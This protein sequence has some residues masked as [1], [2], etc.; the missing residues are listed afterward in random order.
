[1]HERFDRI[2]RTLTKI[3]TELC[4]LRGWTVA[5]QGDIHD[6]YGFLGRDVARFDRFVLRDLALPQG[7]QDPIT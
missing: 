7:P 4:N 6:P 2:D 5:M 3:R 1:M